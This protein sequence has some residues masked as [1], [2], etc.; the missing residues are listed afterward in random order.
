MS[1]VLKLRNPVV[2]DREECKKWFQ[3]QGRCVEGWMGTW[4][5]G[6]VM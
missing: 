6:Y 5:D 1:A 2:E 3:N 4:M